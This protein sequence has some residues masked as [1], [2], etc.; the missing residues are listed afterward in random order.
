MPF[1]PS[2][3]IW[4]LIWMSWALSF[5]TC[6]RTDL[7]EFSRE[8]TTLWKLIPSELEN[9]KIKILL[10]NLKTIGI[11]DKFSNQLFLL[12]SKLIKDL[13][14]FQTFGGRTLLQDPVHKGMESK[15]FASKLGI[16]Q[17]YT[18]LMTCLKEIHMER[19]AF[20]IINSSA[21]RKEFGSLMPICAEIFGLIARMRRWSF[22]ESNF[23]DFVLPKTFSAWET[24]TIIATAKM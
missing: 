2:L 24:P 8:E 21:R 19:M 7:L 12:G 10:C 3:K 14:S 23:S 9:L 15:E 11:V 4:I 16:S 6:S 22:W 17:N 20:N 13:K 18:N 1:S 5:R